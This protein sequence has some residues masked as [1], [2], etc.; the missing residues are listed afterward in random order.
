M[1]F[2]LL[3]LFII[4]IMNARTKNAPGAR[5]KILAGVYPIVERSNNALVPSEKIVPPPISSLIAPRIVIAIVNPSHIPIP[6]KN[7]GIGGFLEA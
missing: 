7:E 4:A 6:S 3:I 2:F 5:I 1:P